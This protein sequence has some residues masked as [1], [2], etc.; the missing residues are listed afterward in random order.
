MAIIS[1]L[2]INFVFVGFYLFRNGDK[3]VLAALQISK[4][5]TGQLS[6][7]WDK[8]QEHWLW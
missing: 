6:S 7:N 3:L 8:Y 1:I 5:E 2:S 4:T